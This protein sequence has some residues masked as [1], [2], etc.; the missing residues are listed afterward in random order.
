MDLDLGTWQQ[1]ARKVRRAAALA[2]VL[3]L[4]GMLAPPVLALVAF[5]GWLL[6]SL[7]VSIVS[8]VLVR[9][10]AGRTVAS[11]HERITAD[12]PDLSRFQV[13]LLLHDGM[14]QGDGC[15]G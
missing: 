1:A 8:L 15:V 11:W 9:R 14:V 4:A 3:W 10:V 6:E 13:A 7:V 12:G 2:R 5:P